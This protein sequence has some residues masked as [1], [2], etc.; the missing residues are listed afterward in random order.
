VSG[1]MVERV[2]AAL[3]QSFKDRVSATAGEPFEATGV[4]APG[5]DVWG[6]YAKAAIAAM[7]EP[8]EDAVIAIVSNTPTSEKDLR[9]AWK[10]LIDNTS[11]EDDE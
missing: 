5:F 6:S 7:R 8:D 9:W 1:E 11:L 10:A 3:E 4:T 2:A